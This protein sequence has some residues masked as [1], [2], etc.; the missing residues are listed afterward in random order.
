MEHKY[1]ELLVH[2]YEYAYI[3]FPISQFTIIFSSFAEDKDLFKTRFLLIKFFSESL[4]T[5]TKSLT[6]SVNQLTGFYLRATLPLNGLIWNLFNKDFIC[7]IR[8]LLINMYAKLSKKTNISY[9]QYVDL[10]EHIRGLERLIFWKIFA[11]ELNARFLTKKL[12][13]NLFLINV[14]N[15][16]PMKTPEK[17][18]FSGVF[19]GYKMGAL[20]RNGLS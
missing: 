13:L 6:A 16:Y 7:L 1:K 5:E 17:R 4:P 3:S 14:F 19:R 9:P 20:A 12:K 8:D 15:L 10:Y 2:V 11:Y 18:R